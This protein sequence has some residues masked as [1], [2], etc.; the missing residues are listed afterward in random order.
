M[1][2]GVVR[3]P[4]S[5]VRTA[6]HGFGLFLAIIGGSSDS[7]ATAFAVAPAGPAGPMA[8]TTV[9]PVGKRD[10]ACRSASGRMRVIG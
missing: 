6:R 5:V 8:V 10:M 9:T 1:S 2:V 3:S 4:E 7:D